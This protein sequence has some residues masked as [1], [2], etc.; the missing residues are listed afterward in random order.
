MGIDLVVGAISEILI[1]QPL[2]IS[3]EN[4]SGHELVIRNCHGIVQRLFQEM[5]HFSFCH[6][7]NENSRSGHSKVFYNG[8]LFSVNKVSENH[9]VRQIF[10]ANFGYYTPRSGDGA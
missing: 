2:E 3:P 6:Y 5:I 8:R 1:N 9:A 7:Y 10:N 4:T